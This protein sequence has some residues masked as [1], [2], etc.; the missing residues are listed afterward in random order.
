MQRAKKWPTLVSSAA[1]TLGTNTTVYPVMKH[2]FMYN[3]TLMLQEY[4]TGKRDDCT[5]TSTTCFHIRFPPPS[6]QTGTPR[7][8]R[9][10]DFQITDRPVRRHRASV[11][12]IHLTRKH[13]QHIHTLTHWT[14]FTYKHTLYTQ[15]HFPYRHFK[16]KNTYGNIT[17]TCLSRIRSKST[18]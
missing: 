1:K 6:C 16:H 10:A 7:G 18:S 14:Y 8:W 5:C 12:N 11:V 3:R 2:A 4:C 9:V 13:A 15:T 17:R